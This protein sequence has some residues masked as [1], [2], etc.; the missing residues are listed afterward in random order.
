MLLFVILLEHVCIITDQKNTSLPPTTTTASSSLDSR[1]S[2]YTMAVFTF[3]LQYSYNDNDDGDDNSTEIPAISLCRLFTQDE[4]ATFTECLLHGYP[5]SC[6]TSSSYTTP[7]YNN[8]ESNNNNTYCSPCPPGT[9]ECLSGSDMV[10]GQ[11]LPCQQ[12]FFKDNNTSLPFSTCV[13]WTQQQCSAGYFPIDG[14]RF[15]DTT[16]I[17]YPPT[18]ENTS[19]ITKTSTP[20]NNNNTTTT[21]TTTECCEW[22][23]DAGWVGNLTTTS[24]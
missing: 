13:E 2:T 11:C 23:C 16:C 6:A 1:K 24:S 7:E 14:N 20:S 21:T 9:C 12:G 8:E 22:A 10:Y 4:E 3:E 15:H 17:P 5:V 19:L 18:P